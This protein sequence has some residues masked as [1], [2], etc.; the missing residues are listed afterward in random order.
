M[1]MHAAGRRPEPGAPEPA[2]LPARPTAG[3]RRVAPSTAVVARPLLTLLPA[4]LLLIPAVGLALTRPPTY[5]A[6]ARMLVGGF[7]VEAAAVPGFV[8]ASRTL[9][10]TYSRLVSTRA[11]V[12]RVA[13]NLDIEIEDAEGNVSATA[14]PESSIIVIEGRADDP[15]TAVRFA[16]AAA[17]ALESYEAESAGASDPA[18]LLD[19]YGDASLAL[20]AAVNRRD[21]LQATYDARVAAGLATSSDLEAVS[22]AEAEADR[23]RLE[24]ETLAAIYGEQRGRR[25]SGNLDLVAP[26][27]ATGNDRRANLQIAIATSV[28]LGGVAGVALVTLVANRDRRPKRR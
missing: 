14:V 19:E 12:E 24:A 25:V 6:E 23:A 8:E 18:D 5:T 10:Q 4:L 2:A 1:T 27:S 7:N 26:A 9:A 28:L 21:V 22:A 13:E 3:D 20:N 15:E 11:I 16:A 17:D